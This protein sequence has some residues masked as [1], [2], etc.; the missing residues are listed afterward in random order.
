MEVLRITVEEEE[1]DRCQTDMSRQIC[2]EAELIVGTILIIPSTVVVGVSVL[3]PA[4]GDYLHLHLAGSS[5]HLLKKGFERVTH[6][7]IFMRVAPGRMLGVIVQRIREI[8]LF[9]IILG[10]S[11]LILVSVCLAEVLGL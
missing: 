1:T 8:L 2:L 11:F 9:I 10:L 3:D 6:H 5:C 4:V 7:Q